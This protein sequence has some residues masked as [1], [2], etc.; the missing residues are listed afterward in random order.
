M[1]VMVDQVFVKGE[2]LEVNVLEVEENDDQRG[3]ETK[4]PSADEAEPGLGS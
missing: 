3:G 1:W 4:H 2:V